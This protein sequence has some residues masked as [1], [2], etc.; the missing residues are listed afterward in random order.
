MAV[1]PRTLD[2]LRRRG[3]LRAVHIGTAGVRFDVRDLRQFIESAKDEGNQ[4]D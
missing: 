1:S 3:Q 4:D 2:N